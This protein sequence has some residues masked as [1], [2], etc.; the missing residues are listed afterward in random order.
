MHGYKVAIVGACGMVGGMFSS[1]LL[2]KKNILS[3]LVLYDIKT[4][5]IDITTNKD[6]VNSCDFTFVCVPTPS[7]YDGSCNIDIVYEVCN[8]IQSK[9]IIIRSTIPPGTSQDIEKSTNKNIVFQPEYLGENPSGNRYNNISK[10]EWTVLGGRKEIT[11]EIAELYLRLYTADFRVF[12]TDHNTAELV[13]YM[14]NSFLSMKTVYCAQMKK[15]AEC[16]GVN[17][18]IARELWLMDDRIGRSHT[19][20]YKNAPGYG[21][22]CFPK[23]VKALI[24]SSKQHGYTP[25]LI[26]KADQIN[27]ILRQNIGY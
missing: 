5:N 7:N 26:E 20:V 15:I 24:A 27:D 23:D 25:D 8:W 22:K 21:G 9:I 16:H 12:Q 1:F 10:N 6:E 18:D 14:T 19:V 17:Y 2:Q 4:T 3:K 13:K 11:A